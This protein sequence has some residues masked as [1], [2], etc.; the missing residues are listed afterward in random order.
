MTADAS[1]PH[2]RASPSPP[3]TASAKAATRAAR[4][5]ALYRRARTAVR[6]GRDAFAIA[7]L[8]RAAGLD[9]S[10][11]GYWLDLGDIYQRTQRHAEALEAYLHALKI[12]PRDRDVFLAIGQALSAQRLFGEAI[13]VLERAL[14]LD[15]A[16]AQTFS[17]L[18]DALCAREAQDDVPQ[19]QSPPQARTQGQAQ[20]VVHYERALQ[21]DPRQA[22]AYRG[23]ARLHAGRGEWRDALAMVQRGLACVPASDCVDLYVDNA[24][25]LLRRSESS[26]ES[27]SASGDVAD[28][29]Q[30]LRAALNERA[31]DVRACRLLVDAIERVVAPSDGSPPSAGSSAGL[32]AGPSDRAQCTPSLTTRSEDGGDVVGAWFSLGAALEAAGDLVQAANAYETAV[33][34]KPDCLRAWL[35]LSDVQLASGEPDKAIRSLE[36]ALAIDPEHPTGH[37]NLGWALRMSG[38]FARGWKESAWN[39][40]AGDKRRFEQPLWDG[41]P[42]DGRTLL[43]WADFALG[44]TI[45]DLRYL[46]RVTAAHPRARLVVECDR[47]LVSLVE[48]N[49]ATLT[50]IDTI[51]ANKAP[52]PSFDVHLPLRRLPEVLGIE[53]TSIP[54]DVP[55]LSAAPARV[56]EWRRRL[57]QNPHPQ[58]HPTPAPNSN[59]TSTANPNPKT[60]GIVWAGDQTRADARTKSASLS[61]FEPLAQIAGLRIISLQLGRN[62]DELI[63]PPPALHVER[64][65]DETCDI[66]DTA[67]VMSLLDLIITVDTMTAHLAGALGKPVWVLAAHAPA[68]WL[69]HADGDRS[70]WYPTMRLFRQDRAGDWEGVMQRIRAALQTDI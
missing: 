66:A 59:P 33:R 41:A 10:H 62:A 37:I 43:L 25:L 46:A 30:L 32:S 68:W 26:S 3:D 1:P 50:P 36:A 52:L 64:L 63:A 65:L 22:N 19:P 9:P 6:Q 53:L 45:Q 12:A 4:P 70:L 55:Y 20:A 39:Y 28:A 11:A 24:D 54:A 38:D 5:R 60:I 14:R 42:L 40:R 56:S 16:R 21:L 2:A 27:G 69:W 17:D 61:A 18:A 49:A 35:R 29:I 44:D 67:A 51:V 48:T 57:A 8:R 13:P 47:R 58:P 34:R 31:R 7:C 23:L 15:P